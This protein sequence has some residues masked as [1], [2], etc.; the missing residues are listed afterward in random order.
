[1]LASGG[2]KG[3]EW[4]T[5]LADHQGFTRERVRVF[6]MPMHPSVPRL[7]PPPNYCCSSCQAVHFTKR[8][9]VLCDNRMKG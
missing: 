9:H 3:G 8:L 1:M 7:A 2:V 5:A 4:V 6:S